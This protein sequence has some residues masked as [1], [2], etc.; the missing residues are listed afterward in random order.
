[1]LG[2]SVVPSDKLYVTDLRVGR[3]LTRHSKEQVSEM[4]NFNHIMDTVERT[5]DTSHTSEGGSI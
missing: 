3:P 4:C 2:V 1:M 5:T